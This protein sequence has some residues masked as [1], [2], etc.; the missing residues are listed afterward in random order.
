VGIPDV[1]NVKL[2]V[3]ERVRVSDLVNVK[4]IVEVIHGD[5]E[6]VSVTVSDLVNG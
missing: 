5:G 4:E 1:V 2:V 3:W 6:R